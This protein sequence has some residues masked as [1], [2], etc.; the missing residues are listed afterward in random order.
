MNF[1]NRK[2]Q[3]QTLQ[4]QKVKLELICLYNK[5]AK[6]LLLPEKVNIKFEGLLKVRSNKDIRGS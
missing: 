3:S 4:V 1:T 2:F 5:L 6:L